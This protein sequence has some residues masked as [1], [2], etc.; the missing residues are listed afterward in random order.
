MTS[1]LQMPKRTLPPPPRQ[2][3]G[4]MVQIRCDVAAVVRWGGAILL[5]LCLMV[6]AYVRPAAVLTLGCAAGAATGRPCAT[7]TTASYSPPSQEPAIRRNDGPTPS[8]RDISSRSLRLSACW[9]RRRSAGRM[10]PVGDSTE[11]TDDDSRSN[12][13]PIELID[14]PACHRS[15]ISARWTA[16]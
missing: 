1:K 16:Q 3:E 13:R 8:P 6:L 9:L 2:T 12:R 4:L 5:A 15:Q 11:N 14:S 10:P 7:P